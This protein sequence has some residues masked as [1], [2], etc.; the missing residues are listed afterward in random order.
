[1]VGHSE[2]ASLFKPAIS[3][4]NPLQILFVFCSVFRITFCS[5][6]VVL[7]IYN[8]RNM[9]HMW[10]HVNMLQLGLVFY[11]IVTILYVYTVFRIKW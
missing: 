1:M 7:T 11:K 10:H 5:F 3:A 9:S 8:Y 2:S 4:H 6:P